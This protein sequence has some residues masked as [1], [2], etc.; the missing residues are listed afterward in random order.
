MQPRLPL[1][2]DDDAVA[3]IPI[4][5]HF[6]AVGDQ[7]PMHLTSQRRILTGMAD[8]YPSHNHLPAPPRP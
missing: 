2:P 6:M 7:P 3:Q 5:E 4:Q 8:E 1:L